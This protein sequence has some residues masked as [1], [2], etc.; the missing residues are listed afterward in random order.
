MDE[1]LE[2]ANLVGVEVGFDLQSDQLTLRFDMQVTGQV[3]AG[4]P[5]RLSHDA[6]EDLIYR[7]RY[8][9]DQARHT[10]NN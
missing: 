9:L 1:K 5:W 3:R 8:A 7:L 10:G 6:A 2:Y 4:R